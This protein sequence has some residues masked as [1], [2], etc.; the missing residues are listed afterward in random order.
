M[1]RSPA[2]F[3]PSASTSTSEPATSPS[4]LRGEGGLRVGFERV[5][6]R[7]GGLRVGFGR[8]LDLGGERVGVFFQ[9]VE[10][11]LFERAVILPYGRMD[12]CVNR[13]G[14]DG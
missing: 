2:P 4:P 8:G 1:G 10:V 3:D 13:K 12:G 7:G 9:K 14:K 6:F 5:G 11:F